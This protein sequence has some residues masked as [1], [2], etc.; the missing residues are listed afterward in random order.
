MSLIVAG[1]GARGGVHAV[2]ETKITWGED[3]T[4]TAQVWRNPWRKL[5]ILRPDL[6][7]GVTGSGYEESCQHLVD[8]AQHG[9]AEHVSWAAADLIDSDVIVASLNPLRLMRTRFGE[10][11]D[12]TESGRAWAGDE[13]AY[14]KFQT[15]ESPAFGGVE[16]LGL[17]APMQSLAN[18]ERHASV[19]GYTLRVD[20]DED[21]FRFTPT[22]M[23]VPGQFEACVLAGTSSTPGAFGIHLPRSGVGYLYSQE[24]PWEPI[25]IRA[26]A[27]EDI[28]EAAGTY[29]QVLS[30]G[31][32]CRAMGVFP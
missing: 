5:L 8:A 20:T 31:P 6:M 29:G 25:E 2:A 4:R 24:R 18:F 16:E 13:L 27:C 12:E 10:R 21:G 28:V 26:E 9:T 11:L 23:V 14:E 7:I 19:G 32:G 17:Q 15:L 30:L 3:P 1:I 22:P